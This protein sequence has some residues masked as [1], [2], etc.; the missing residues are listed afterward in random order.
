MASRQNA[1][2]LWVGEIVRINTLYVEGK[3]WQWVSTGDECSC[4]W[5]WRSRSVHS[6]WGWTLL[7]VLRQVCPLM[8]V[9]AVGGAQAG[10]ST[11]ECGCYWRWRCRSVWQSNR[12]NAL[13]MVEIHNDVPHTE[14]ATCCCS[15]TAIFKELR[16]PVETRCCD[17]DHPRVT[18]LELND[19]LRLRPKQNITKNFISYCTLIVLT[20]RL[21]SRSLFRFKM[22][23]TVRH[24]VWT[25]YTTD[26][27]L[28]TSLCI[29]IRIFAIT[30]NAFR[31]NYCAI[32]REVRHVRYG[33]I[34]TEPLLVVLSPWLTEGRTFRL[35]SYFGLRTRCK[36]GREYLSA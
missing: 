26:L 18:T 20:K 30:P 21:I 32:I 1:H 9:H 7:E 31:H 24:I 25:N 15:G 14:T 6:W 27:L 19:G 12:Q 4:C 2:S 28:C 34:Y 36:S 13:Y 8:S 23:Y 10:V 11:N 16:N 17:L 5:R 22:F 35:I 29:L 33:M 3:V